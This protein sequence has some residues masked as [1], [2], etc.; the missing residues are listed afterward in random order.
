MDAPHPKRLK[1]D[2]TFGAEVLCSAQLWPS[3]REKEKASC[4]GPTAAFD[5]LCVPF[6]DQSFLS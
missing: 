1:Q 2:Q 4:K 5:A 3:P 6:V